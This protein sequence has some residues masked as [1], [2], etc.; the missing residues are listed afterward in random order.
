MATNTKNNFGIAA[1]LFNGRLN[2]T[3]DLFREKTDNLI[4]PL[5]VAPSTGFV[6]YQDNLGS[7]KNTGY[8]FSISSPIIRN[9]Q[10]NIFW[11]LSFNAGHYKNVITK[12]SPAIEAVE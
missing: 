1:G 6:T 4:L 5:D 10:K 9:S 11:S 12:L 3:V 7:T 8:E 2:I